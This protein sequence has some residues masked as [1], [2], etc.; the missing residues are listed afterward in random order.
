MFSSCLMFND[1]KAF[2]NRF[3]LYSLNKPGFLSHNTTYF[4]IR[5]MEEELKEFIY[6]Y[7]AGNL[8]D[9]FD[10]LIDLVYV[11]MGT[12][13]LMRLPWEDGWKTVHTANMKKIRAKHPSESKRMYL[14]DVIKPAGWQA[15]N[16]KGLL[17]K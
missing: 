3:E 13:Y 16:I 4:R 7:Q 11:A 6:A 14:H 8:A 17:E 5:F 1:I 12:A 2:H 15:P 9:A 10:A